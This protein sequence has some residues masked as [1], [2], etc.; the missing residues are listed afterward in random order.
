M[1]LFFIADDRYRY[2]ATLKPQLKDNTLLRWN[3]WHTEGGKGGHLLPGAAL[4]GAKLRSEC[5]VLIMNANNYNL[6]NLECHC[7]IS[8]RSPRFAKR[9]IMNLSPKWCFKAEFLSTGVRL[10]LWIDSRLRHNAF[11][12][13]GLQAFRLT[14]HFIV[15]S[16]WD[17]N[18]AFKVDAQCCIEHAF[19][20]AIKL[21]QCCYQG[22]AEGAWTEGACKCMLH[23][24]CNV[25]RRAEG[26]CKCMLSVL[27]ETKDCHHYLQLCYWAKHP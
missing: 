20:T 5:Y 4:W 25:C 24:P 8:S 21:A 2:Y 3:Q 18:P 27:R 19:R 7:E 10:S 14:Y 17:G 6:R 16:Q 11:R 15:A 9:A 26:A 1:I 23:A 12:K 13:P 22:C